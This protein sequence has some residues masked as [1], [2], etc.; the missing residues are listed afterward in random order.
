MTN[1]EIMKKYII[2]KI[3]WQTLTEINEDGKHKR[4]KNQNINKK[5]IIALVENR[6]VQKVDGNLASPK[7]P[8]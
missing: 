5:S 6:T 8:W 1:N 3:K 2:K 7:I 4:K